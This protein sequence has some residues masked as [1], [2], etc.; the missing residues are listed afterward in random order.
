MGDWGLVDCWRIWKLNNPTSFLEFDF[1]SGKCKPIWVES[2]PE[3]TSLHAAKQIEKG[4][5]HNLL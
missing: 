5:K 1:G 3:K 2:T 4:D